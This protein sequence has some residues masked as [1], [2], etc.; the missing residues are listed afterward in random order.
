MTS[1]DIKSGQVEVLHFDKVI[2][3]TG[4]LNT[5]NDIK[6]KGQERFSGELIHSRQFKDPGSY[7]GKNVMVAGVGATGV[8]TLVFLKQ[9]GVG[10]LYNSH[11]EQYWVVS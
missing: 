4:I 9:A 2:L 10:K 5:P 11:R 8:D 7:K 6:I 3:A 1:K